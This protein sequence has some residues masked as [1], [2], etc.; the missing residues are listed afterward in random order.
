[1]FAILEMLRRVQ[2]NF[3]RLE[4]EHI[5]NADQFRVT[6]EVPLPYVFTGE[7]DSDDEDHG[8]EHPARRLSV[9]LPSMHKNDS[10]TDVEAEG[11]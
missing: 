1:M 8:V 10:D 3:F 4:N 6:R 9:R 11:R 2:W 7:R 5:G